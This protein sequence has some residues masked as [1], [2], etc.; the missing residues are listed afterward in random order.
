MT[1]HTLKVAPESNQSRATIWRK[2]Q[3]PYCY[4]N[5]VTAIYD[6]GKVRYSCGNCNA[7]NVIPNRVVF[8]DMNVP[9][10]NEGK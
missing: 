6:V 7:V 1:K 5:S 4:G 10:L 3:C 9:V 2:G 8:A